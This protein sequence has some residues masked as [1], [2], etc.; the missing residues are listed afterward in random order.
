MVLFEFVRNI[1]KMNENLFYCVKSQKC[2]A[3]N[4][5][6]TIITTHCQWRICSGYNIEYCHTA[7]TPIGPNSLLIWHWLVTATTHSFPSIFYSNGKQ[8]LNSLW[9]GHK[10]VL[11]WCGD[12]IISITIAFFQ[13]MFLSVTRQLLTDSCSL[14]QLLTDS[15][16]L[17]KLLNDSCS[18][19]QLLT[20]QLLTCTVAHQ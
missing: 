12:I 14:G 19:G 13:D 10:A 18:L 4:Y 15:C 2:D 1:E 16:S 9:F 11:I 7:S 6:T 8:V 3:N 20:G 17:G 5:L